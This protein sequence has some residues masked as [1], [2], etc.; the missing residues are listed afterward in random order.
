[1]MAFV[2]LGL[3]GIDAVLIDTTVVPC[4]YYAY[5]GGV[6]SAVTA[7]VAKPLVG[8]AALV[9]AM[10]AALYVLPLMVDELSG[11][12]LSF[13]QDLIPAGTD[14]DLYNHY[15]LLLPSAPTSPTSSESAVKP[16]VSDAPTTAPI[17]FDS[18]LVLTIAAVLGLVIVS[19]GVVMMMNRAV[20]KE[21]ARRQRH[22]ALMKRVA[23][24]HQIA[25]I[26]QQRWLV[27]DKDIAALL[28][29]PAMRMW[30]D[31]KTAATVDAMNAYDAISMMKP[32]RGDDPDRAEKVVTQIEAA[33]QTLTKALDTA[34]RNAKGLAISTMSKEERNA[35]RR[36]Q[37]ALNLALDPMATEAERERALHV[38][39]STLDRLDITPKETL[40][41]HLEKKTHQQ[42]EASPM[43]E[44]YKGVVL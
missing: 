14:Q 44:T 10:C 33:A 28:A 11:L 2:L 5:P 3:A 26:A 39:R 20:Q 32:S 29:A 8:L 1:M 15:G 42:I 40:M 12:I 43:V 7:K 27:Y 35:L 37:A 38:V 25:E 17:H 6:T 16:S 18:G 41:A 19:W 13:A 23:D 4:L 36:A 31:E 30:S 24:A 22:R 34:E 9:A 21:A